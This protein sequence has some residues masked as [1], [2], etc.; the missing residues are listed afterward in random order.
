MIS[1]FDIYKIGVGPSSS[2][3][4]GPMK[5]GKQFIDDLRAMGKLRDITKITVD[6]YGSLS[7]TGK[8]HHT[9]IAIVMGLA[10]NTPEK[11]DIDAIPNFMARVEE[12]E[13]LPV[14]MHCHTVDFPREGGMNFHKTNLSL[15]ENGMQIHAWIDDEVVYA[16]TYYSIGGGF[17][18]DEESFGKA[19][20]SPIQV[21]YPF[22]SAEQLINQCQEHGL[23]ISTLVMANE[24][25]MH[26]DE[27]VHSYFA[28]IWRTMR[29]CM[30]RGMSTE[31]ILPGPLRVPRR[32]AALRQQL[33]TSEKTTNDPMAVVDWVNMYAFAVNEENA[34]G[35]RVVTAPTN[36]ACGIIPAVLAYYDK[37]IQTVTEKDYIRYFAASGAIGGLYKQNASISGAEVGC[38]GEVGVACS[39]AA[40]GLAE[41]LGGSPEQVCMAAE[42]AMEH[43]LGLTC[44][45]VAGQVQV[46]CIER[47]GIAAVKAI[48]STRMAMRRSSAPRVSLDKVIE[49][50]LETGKDMNAKYRETSQGGLAVKVIC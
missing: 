4:V 33:L 26:S 13:R 21:P 41:L 2:H 48:N 10:G 23:S 45:P 5:A 47:N 50:M 40:A 32:A 6:V 9:D 16:K 38:Q 7:L 39:M 44:D 14:G 17:I 42:I 18:V 35:G 3:T 30:E 24:K 31:G 22:S 49:T 29:E 27:E 20:D 25:A 12:T 11:V 28:N 8:G 19:I 37:F 1:V 46:P 36:G 43:N 15:H 34:A